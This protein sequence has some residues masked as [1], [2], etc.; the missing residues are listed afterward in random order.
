[1]EILLAVAVATVAV[2]SWFTSTSFRTKIRENTAQ[3][4]LATQRVQEAERQL[5]AH[6]A[7]SEGASTGLA[8]LKQKSELQ[9]T[10]VT[11]DLA[12]LD[13]H[14][15][16]LGQFVRMRLDHEVTS[17]RASSD[18]RVLVGGIHTDRP[19]AAGSLPALFESFLKEVP[20]E[21]L[22]HD[23]ADQYGIRCYL[24]WTSP[25]GQ[26]LEQR[27]DTLLRGCPQDDGPAV[28]GL[29]ELRALLVALYSA[30]PGTLQV[31]PLITV[32]ARDVFIGAV[33]DPGQ[34]GQLDPRGLPAVPA[35]AAAQL[36]E[37]AGDRI[38]DL[39]EWAAD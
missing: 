19:T 33:L 6:G 30:G 22:F 1:M 31:G 29:G 12:H 4:E 11:R 8:D 15:R 10:G 13:R 24:A 39:S 5:R 16:D 17:T 7:V 9:L 38:V 37:L 28:P 25:N 34:A 14:V 20:V 32:R 3:L 36:K 26:S 2:A 35:E 23:T 21:T 18:H 27:L